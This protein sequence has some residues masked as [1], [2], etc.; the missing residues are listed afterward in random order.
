MHPEA[1]GQ[2]LLKAKEEEKRRRSLG[3]PIKFPTKQFECY[4]VYIL[5]QSV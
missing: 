4:Y 3:V 2:M 1:V 5:R